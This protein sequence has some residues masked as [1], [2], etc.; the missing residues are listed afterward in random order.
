MNWYHPKV[1]TFAPI[2]SKKQP[3]KTWKHLLSPWEAWSELIDTDVTQL[4][5]TAQSFGC[6][7]WSSGGTPTEFNQVCS[8]YLR[9]QHDQFWRDVYGRLLLDSTSHWQPSTYSKRWVI[10]APHGVF[11]VVGPNA[12]AC[13]LTVFRPHP[14]G[15][16]VQ[17]SEDDFIVFARN[18]W[19]K[20]TGVSAMNLIFELERMTSDPISL[21]RLAHAVALAED[22]TELTIVKAKRNAALWLSNLPQEVKAAAIPDRNQLLDLLQLQFEEEEPETVDTLWGLEDALL[23]THVLAGKAAYDGLLDELRAVLDWAPPSWLNLATLAESRLQKAPTIAR[24]LW[25]HISATIDALTLQQL[26][27]VHRPIASIS[28]N[29]LAPTWW[30]RWT[31]KLEAA[32]RSLTA[33]EAGWMVGAGSMSGTG[34]RWHVVPPSIPTG[35]KVFL[36]H[37]AAPEGEDVT[38]EIL[39]GAV[40]WELEHPGEEIRVILVTGNI[41]GTLAEMV[42]AADQGKTQLTIIEISRPR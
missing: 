33:S 3:Q 32:V 27:V 6:P 39:P 1:G 13:V 4:R 17:S 42:A 31:S 9:L 8:N 18:Y 35:T 23:V 30:Q 14:F 34:D 21:W 2:S 7:A 37:A 41:N 12:P 19:E 29:L 15:L 16:N 38:T 26:P 20:E 11:G 25:E 22:A 10:L 24:P 40:F 5:N 28:H 36:V